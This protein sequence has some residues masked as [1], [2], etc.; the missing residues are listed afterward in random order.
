MTEHAFPFD[1]KSHAFNSPGILTCKLK[2]IVI[3][4]LQQSLDDIEQKN[5]DLVDFSNQ[6]AGHNSEEYQL[7]ITPKIKYL[8]ESLSREYDKIFLPAPLYSGYFTEEDKKVGIKYKLETLWVNYSKKYDFNPSHT[9]GGF[10]SF[11]I[12]VKIPYDLDKE[13]KL[14][15]SNTLRTSAFTFNYPNS[16]GSIAS[17]PI[18]LDK[19]WEWT[20][21]LFPSSLNHEVHPFYTSDDTRISI[22]GNIYG[23]KNDK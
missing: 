6:L 1:F 14:Y 10:Y 4:E 5:I 18:F 19:T 8:V 15:K 16:L 21:A 3:E 22:S 13:L 12:W 7:P 23:V 9:H 17:H 11:V 2:D 20:M